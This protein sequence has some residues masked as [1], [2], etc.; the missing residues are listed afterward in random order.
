MALIF[1]YCLYFYKDE[2]DMNKESGVF[3]KII[4]GFKITGI[5]ITPLGVI[6]SIIKDFNIAAFITYGVI[7]ALIYIL[8][9]LIPSPHK[10]DRFYSLQDKNNFVRASYSKLINEL[11]ERANNFNGVDINDVNTCEAVIQINI[12][13][14]NRFY[15][16]VLDYLYDGQAIKIFDS[17]DNDYYRAAYYAQVKNGVLYLTDGIN[18]IT[19]NNLWNEMINFKI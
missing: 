5:I 6:F 7:A 18:D 19:A 17:C 8:C 10:H 14:G 15:R 2:A 11:K 9:W 12:N 3:Q 16:I 4:N 1:Y 13:E